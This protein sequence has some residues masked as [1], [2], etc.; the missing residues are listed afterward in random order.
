MNAEDELYRDLQIHLDK[1]TIGFPSTESESDIRLL[2]QLFPPDEAEMAML[3]TYKF[4][5]LEQ[6]HKRGKKIGKSLEE[7][8]QVLDKTAKQGIIGYSEKNGIK[9]YKNIPYM[10]VA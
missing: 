2:K 5:D 7:I 6:I 3:L 10:V 8:E 1:Q 9:Q 4:E